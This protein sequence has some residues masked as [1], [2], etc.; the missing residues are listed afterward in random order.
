MNPVLREGNSDRYTYIQYV[1]TIINLPPYRILEREK[2]KKI[3][4]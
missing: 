2:E 4:L 3:L 1:S